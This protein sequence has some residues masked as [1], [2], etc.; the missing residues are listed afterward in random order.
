MVE[1]IERICIV[2][3]T[4]EAIDQFIAAES[5]GGG[6]LGE[7]KKINLIEIDPK[8]EHFKELRHGL[9]KGFEE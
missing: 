4:K 8:T 6:M 9:I 3:G 5:W 2:Y 1:K 7:S